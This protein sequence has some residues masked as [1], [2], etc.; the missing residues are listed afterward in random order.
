MA[1]FLKQFYFENL[2]LLS[3]KSHLTSRNSPLFGSPG[4]VSALVLKNEDR[5][6]KEKLSLLQCYNPGKALKEN[7]PYL[8]RDFW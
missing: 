2:P 8:N 3:Q 5:M 1:V 6:N 7:P 4:K